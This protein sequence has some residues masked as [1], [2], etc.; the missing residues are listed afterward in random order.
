M[1]NK[2]LVSALSDR[3]HT[4]GTPLACVAVLLQTNPETNMKTHRKAGPCYGQ[5][6]QA[7]PE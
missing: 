6:K 3:G 2:Q 7:P 5:D 1:Y 4:L